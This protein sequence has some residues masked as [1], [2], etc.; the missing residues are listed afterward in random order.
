[1]L[2]AGGSAIVNILSILGQVGMEN[3]TPYVAAK[4]GVVGLTKNVALEY[5]ARGIRANAVGPAFIKT[6]LIRELD[7]TSRNQVRALHPL[8]RLG[9]PEEVAELVAWLS[10]DRASFV[11]GNYYAV[12]GG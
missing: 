8:G 11:T 2:E 7:E 9:K 5:G 1:M 4:P 12:D 6:G 10:S 3:A